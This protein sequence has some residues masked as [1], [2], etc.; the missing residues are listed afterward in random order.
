MTSSTSRF[1]IMKEI[2]IRE[3]H[4]YKKTY[5]GGK[6]AVGRYSVIYVLKDLKAYK[7]RKENPK[8]EYVNR[9]GLAVTKK[10]GGAVVRNR[11]KR[12]LRAALRSVEKEYG[13]RKGFLIV[14]SS[15][16]AASRVSSDEIRT[17]M[18]SQ[19]QKLGLISEK[20]GTAAEVSSA[21]VVAEMAE[22]AE[23]KTAEKK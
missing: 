7:L 13:L 18:I 1:L 8:K 4:L 12:V 5:L 3:N 14:I 23:E 2:A 6:K 10:M 11:I 19:L 21:G 22:V 17:E 9:I 16:E 20:H 15:R